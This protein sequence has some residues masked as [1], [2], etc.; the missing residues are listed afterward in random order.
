M[1]FLL[2]F[3]GATGS[4]EETPETGAGV[5]KRIVGNVY[6]DTKEDL[7]VV[8][9][10]KATESL[11]LASVQS[12]VPR[13]AEYFPVMTGKSEG[14]KI[15]A[16]DEKTPEGIYTIN[17]YIPPVKLDGSLYGAG[18]FPL[19]YPNLVDRIHGKTGY[20]IWIHGR[21]SQTDSRGTRGCVSLEN[22]NFKDLRRRVGINT[23]VIITEKLDYY[24]PDEYAE[25]RARHLKTLKSFI[26]AWEKSDYDTFASFFHPKFRSRSG[27][28]YDAY[29]RNKKRLMDRFSYRKITISN[30]A[31]FKE[32]SHELVYAFDQL[33]CAPNLLNAG[34]KELF[35]E[36]DET[37]VPKIIAEQFSSGGKM[38]YIRE[39]VSAFLDTWRDAWRSRDIERYMSHYART[40]EAGGKSYAEWRDYKD[41]LFHSSVIRSIDVGNLKINLLGTTRT[42]VV[43]TQD[44]VSDQISDRGTKT[45]VLEGCPG[46]YRIASESWKPSS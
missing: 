3:A 7:S 26:A 28:S 43:F 34:R 41:A 39:E 2:P 25:Q 40:F 10:E 36:K 12:N 30:V 13:V 11:Y 15:F 20:G 19:S 24:S 27:M 9:V 21:G 16:G 45:L 18:A 33:Y 29:L 6:T 44:Y 35:L 32:N 14:D 46:D 22:E 23:P 38:K 17:R 31:I 8:L 42:R 1:V 37:G 5:E 4:N